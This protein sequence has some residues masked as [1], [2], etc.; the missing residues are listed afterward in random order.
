MTRLISFCTSPIVAATNAVVA[1]RKT[2]KD[3]AVGANSMIG[4]MR[5]TRKTPA[6]TMVAAWIRADTGVGP[7]IASGNHVCRNSCADLPMAP[8]NN[9]RAIT[10]AAFQSRYKNVMV[11]WDSVSAS[12][13]ITSKLIDPVM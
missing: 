13:K 3:I 9:S 11:D 8:T 1:P 6:V 7:S 2:T 4:A 10:S 5:Q 12:A